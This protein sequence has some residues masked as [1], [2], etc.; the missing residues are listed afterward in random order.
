LRHFATVVEKGFADGCFRF[1]TR[2]GQTIWMSVRAVRLPGER[3][4]AFCQD[5][6]ESKQAEDALRARESLLRAVVDN[7]PFEFWARDLEEYCFME[8]TVLVQHWGSILGRRPEDTAITPEELALWKDNNRRAFAGE[9][10]DE[11]VAY[12]MGDEQHCFHNIVA[13]IRIEGE[14]RGILGLNIDITDRRRMI[15]ELDR[16]R[17]HLEDLIAERTVELASARDVAEAASRAK[18]TFLANMSHELRTPMNA[19]MGMTSIVLRRATDPQLVN[20]LTKI[21][22]A[23]HHLLCVINDIL[24]F[25]KIEAG[26]LTLELVSF[27][28]GPVLENLMSMLG[29]RAEEK[30]LTL[31]VDLPP[32]IA[33]QSFLGDPL[34]L[35][36]ILLNLAGNAV[37]FT[38]QGSITVRIMKLE[39]TSADVLLRCEVLDT[40]I[41]IRPEGQQRLF[42][43]FEQA[44]GSMTRKYGGTG[45]GLVISR[46]L[47][48]LMG[49][50]IA[51]SS[52]SGQGSSFWL[53]V[54][55]GKMTDAA[56][57]A[58]TVAEESAETQLQA[59]HAGARIL[60]AEDEPINQ[61]VSRGLLEDVGLTVD[62]A[63]DGGAAVTIAQRSHYDLILMDMQM[64]QMNGVEATRMIRTLPAYAHTPILAMTANA[65]DEDRQLCRDAGMDD[66]IGKPVDPGKLYDT[67]LTWLEKSA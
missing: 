38:D 54:R 16:H 9:V 3:F 67:L 42:T 33:Q 49:G 65:F 62:V 61:E 11:E 13:P 22:K 50:D 29:P 1:R 45:L 27:K 15:Q 12:R 30:E 48:E 4:M 17:H 20:M 21:D 60:L 26:R 32:D 37:K 58:P 19:I 56:P 34:R 2:S 6:T 5:I 24:D 51:L 47:A 40:G 46:R 28:F 35:G 14:I 10:V 57:P 41:G 25:S 36:Q 55:L 63:E 44:D 59:R 39:E 52:T 43:A 18:S 53:T 23:S 8:N 66:H 31:F 64:P 7:T